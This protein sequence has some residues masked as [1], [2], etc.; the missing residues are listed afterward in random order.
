MN[1]QYLLLAGLGLLVAPTFLLAATEHRQTPDI[2]LLTEINFGS[3]HTDSG[4]NDELGRGHVY[5]NDHDLVSIGVRYNEMTLGYSQF[6]NSYY[7]ESKMVSLEY[8]FSAGD[9]PIELDLGV[10]VIDGYKSEIVRKEE[11]FFG[12]D[13]MIAPLATLSLRTSHLDF[14]GLSFS[15]KVRMMG[16]SAFMINLE[17]GYQ[18]D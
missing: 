9:F 1:R 8:T 14:A 6:S 5:N 7:N 13:Y 3:K 4:Y 12:D 11:F 18:L 17:I 10:A 16:F 2:S 15:P